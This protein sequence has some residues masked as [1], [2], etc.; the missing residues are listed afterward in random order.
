MAV[1][2]AS[3]ILYLLYI[4]NRKYRQTFSYIQHF[5]LILTWLQV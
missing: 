2:E 4:V 1:P 5:V 3:V